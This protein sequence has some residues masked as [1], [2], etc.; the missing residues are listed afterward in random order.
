MPKF[1][2]DTK[3]LFDSIRGRKLSYTPLQ[4]IEEFEA[5]INDLA[6]NPIECETDYKQQ[7][8]N[9]GRKQ[10]R[11]TQVFAR[12]PKV[13]D[14]VVRWLGM[15]AM[16]WYKLP[17]GKKGE[18]YARVIER[19]TQ[20]CYDVKFDG[21]AIGLYNAN[22]IARDL[23]LRENVHHTTENKAEEE[24]SIEELKAEIKRLGVAIDD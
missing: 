1:Y 13:L 16:W 9:T 6:A 22:I 4:I 23:A 5:Y 11:R 21:A 20:Y 8:E 15:S 2:P 24:L 7:A 10:N 19:I 18:H 3:R 12:P 14:F 17:E